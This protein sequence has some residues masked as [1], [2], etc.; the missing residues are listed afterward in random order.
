MKCIRPQADYKNIRLLNTKLIAN[1]THGSSNP[2]LFT[3]NNVHKNAFNHTL[4]AIS[5]LKELEY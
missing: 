4:K 1:I 5:I 3:F 2:G